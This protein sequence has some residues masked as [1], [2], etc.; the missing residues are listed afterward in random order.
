[1]NENEATLIE[2]MTLTMF[3]T[4]VAEQRLQQRIKEEQERRKKKTK[5][6]KGKKR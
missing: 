3:G 5:K 2:A 6:A 4:S 1:M